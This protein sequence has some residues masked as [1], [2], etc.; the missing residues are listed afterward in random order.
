MAR[1]PP[2]AWEASAWDDDETLWTRVSEWALQ[3]VLCREHQT[4]S[5][6]PTSEIIQRPDERANQQVTESFVFSAGSAT[7]DLRHS[8][9]QDM[10]ELSAEARVSALQK[11]RDRFSSR[12][13]KATEKKWVL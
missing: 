6:S 8:E 5:E 4:L 3:P 9:L 7:R 11:Y 1:C 13:R 10:I 2:R 12:I